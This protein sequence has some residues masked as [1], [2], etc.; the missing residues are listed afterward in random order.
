MNYRIT[1]IYFSLLLFLPAGY[2]QNTKIA[3]QVSE[4]QH[5]TLHY[6]A[7]D[8]GLVP[9]L[10]ETLTRG[11]AEN[12]AFFGQPFPRR[13][14]VWCF[15]DRAALDRQWQHDWGDSTFQSACWMVAS[16]VAQRL[17]LL[18]PRVWATQA[19]DH[20]VPVV[21]AGAGATFRNEKEAKEFQRL[22]TH[23]LT[24]VYH[25]QHCRVPD[26]AGL[27]ALGWWIEGLA[28]YAS[29]QFDSTRLARVKTLVQEGKAP[30]QLDQFWSGSQRYGLSGSVVA[31]LDAHFG[32]S[33]LLSLLPLDSPAEV[34]KALG[35]KEEE[36]LRIWNEYLSK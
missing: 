34:F 5:F 32:R 3:W 28:T 15:P 33:V 14:D 31:A 25:G 16:G 12:S 29:G 4:N 35:L 17:D 21:A 26:F 30:A 19:C 36:V 11:V 18:S 9:I 23:E 7:P 24:H 1:I 8:S 6:T 2:A 20:G 10:T 27:D 13:F 22:F